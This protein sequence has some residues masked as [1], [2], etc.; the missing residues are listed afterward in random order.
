MSTILFGFSFPGIF[1]LMAVF[2]KSINPSLTLFPICLF[3]ARIA[4]TKSFAKK[5]GSF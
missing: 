3:L 5:D 1:F 4:L 2:I